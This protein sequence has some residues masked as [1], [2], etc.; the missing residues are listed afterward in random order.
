MT[1]ITDEDKERV[2]LLNLISSSKN[3]F[4]KLSLEQLKRLQELVEKKNYSH[5]KKAHK[6]KVKLLGKI[7]V[8][9]YEITEGRGIWG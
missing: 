8:R 2:K 6:S 7:N 1:E 4:K 3:E 9:I 5:D